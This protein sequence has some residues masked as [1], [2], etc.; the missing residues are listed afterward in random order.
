MDGR[1]CKAGGARMERTAWV[2]ESGAFILWKIHIMHLRDAT[3][4]LNVACGLSFW[5]WSASGLRPEAFFACAD[6]VQ[7]YP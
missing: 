4:E 6:A 1:A 3:S 5:L 2:I 7:Q